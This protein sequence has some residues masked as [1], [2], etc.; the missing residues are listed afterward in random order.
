MSATLSIEELS[1]W[2]EISPD[3]MCPENKRRV[4][5]FR[6]FQNIA[7]QEEKEFLQNLGRVVFPEEFTE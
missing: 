6:G 1:A 2:Y 3:S 7:T 4:L 5:E